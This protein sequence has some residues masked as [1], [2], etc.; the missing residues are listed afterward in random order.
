M[1][2]KV[3]VIIVTYNAMKWVDRCFDSLRQSEMP[4]IPVVIDNQSK[5]DTVN[6]IRKHYPEAHIIV[7]NE[8]RGFGQANNQGIE[9]AYNQG[10]THFFLLNQ[11]A[12]VHPDTIDKLVNIQDKYNIA[13]VSPIHLNGVGDKMD[14]NF[15]GKIVLNE[16]NLDYVSDLELGKCKDYYTV[17]K[18]NAA[19]WML[20]RETIETIGGFDPIY[21]HYGEDGNYCQRIKYHKKQVAFIPSAYVHHDR[22]LQGNMK[23]FKKQEIVMHLLYCYSDV[24]SGLFKNV[25][26]KAVIHAWFTKRALI[27]LVTG[28]IQNFWNILSGYISFL[29]KIPQIRISMKEN[30]KVA[31]TW[32]NLYE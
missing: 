10:G 19:A 8:N 12:W 14:Y 9:W 28:K 24:N 1:N 2:T 11:D 26:R 25:K 29:I 15:F 21:F 6:Y 4:C 5:D 17:F 3:Y 23:V 27:A 30:K 13:L 16:I 32:L 22:N 7:N 18:I 31:H 20:S